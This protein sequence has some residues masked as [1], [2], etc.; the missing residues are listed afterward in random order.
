M[1][2]QIDELFGDFWT[3]AGLARS[4]AGFAPRSTSTTAESRHGGDKGGPVGDRHRRRQPRGAGAHARDQRRARAR[5]PEG[6]VY[7]QIEIERGRS[8]ARWSSA[9]RSRPRGER[10]LR[11]RHPA[12]RASARARPA[13][14]RAGPDR[15]PSDGRGR[16]DPRDRGRPG[17]AQEIRRGPRRTLPA[18]LPVLPLR[19]MVAFPNTMTPLAVGQER[20]V[21]S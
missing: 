18:V 7:Q 19:E 21:R 5:D 8:S 20:S 3:R 4:R 14:T 11:G 16:Q 6:R 10:H 9:S 15:G 2:R 13:R 1:R 12:R 17:R